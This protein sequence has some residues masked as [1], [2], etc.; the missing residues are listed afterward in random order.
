MWEPMKQ[1]KVKTFNTCQKKTKCTLANKLVKLRQLLDR[2]LVVQQARPTM[3][4][5]LQKIIGI[6][7]F[8]SIPRSLFSS[9][10][11]LFI[12]ND[13]SAII[14]YIEEYQVEQ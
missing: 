4:T 2:F 14:H 3:I 12:P 9:D 7:E 1:I 5:S 10:G 13:K 6:Y 11:L 8:S